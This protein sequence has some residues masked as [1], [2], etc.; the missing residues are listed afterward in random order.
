MGLVDEQV[1]TSGLL[2][3][4]PVVFALSRQ[5]LFE[6]FLCTLFRGL[7]LFDRG[8]VHRVPTVRQLF[9]EL[10]DL[11]LQVVG[12]PVFADVDQLEH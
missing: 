8:R 7:D 9:A 10:V 2:E 11:G 6:P 12:A 4:H 3:R 5:Q 1:V